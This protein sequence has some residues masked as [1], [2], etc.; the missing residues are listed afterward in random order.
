MC[1]FAIVVVC[2][3]IDKAVSG[4]RECATL[5]GAAETGRHFSPS[6]GQGWRHPR[7]VRAVYRVCFVYSNC[8][9][10]KPVRVSVCVSVC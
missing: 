8:K 9:M 3:K 6:S 4:S 10:T 2:V 5:R 7:K 1:G